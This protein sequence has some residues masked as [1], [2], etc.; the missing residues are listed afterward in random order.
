MPAISL[1]FS[2][3][4][5]M[6]MM[7]ALE[8][9]GEGIKVGGELIKDV[10]YAEDQGMIA[11]TE[12]GLQSLM[13]SLN[14]T[15]KHYDIKINIKKT[16]AMVVLRNGGERVNMTV[17]GQSVEQVSKCRYLGSLISEDGRCLDDVKTRIGMPKDA[18]NKRKELLTRSIRVDLRKRLVK[19]L[20]WPVVLYGCETWTM[21]KEEINRLDAFEIWVWRRMGKVSWMDKRTNEQVLSSMNEKR[22]LIKTIWDRKKNGLDMF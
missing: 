2:I 7:E 20:V 19:T 21:R 10:K 18:F 12:A 22:S 17:E 11:N 14:T 5:E 6:M 9:L 16:K 8:N 4:A 15:V 1:L 3:Y 13:N